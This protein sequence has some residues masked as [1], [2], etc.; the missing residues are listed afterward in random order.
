M[1]SFIKNLFKNNDSCIDESEH[2]W[3]KYTAY[4]LGDESLPVYDCKICNKCKK[5]IITHEYDL[6][7]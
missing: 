7:F 3:T 2:D 6:Q 1:F 5:K 4:F